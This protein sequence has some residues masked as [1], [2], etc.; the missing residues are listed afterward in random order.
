MASFIL[1]NKA[2]E[3]LSSIWSYTVEVWSEEQ[4]DKYYYNI[5]DYCKG[6]SNG[7]FHGKVYPK[8]GENICG[9]RINQHIL[10]YTIS[11]DSNLEILRILHSRMDLRNKID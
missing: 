11:A 1:S 6:L 10:F 4:A 9:F 5:L 7:K 2:V 3:D 8:I